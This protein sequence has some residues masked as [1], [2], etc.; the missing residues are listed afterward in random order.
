MRRRITAL[1]FAASLALGLGSAAATSG[2]AA[3]ADGGTSAPNM[4]FHD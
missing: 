3:H 4:M 2:T 1:V